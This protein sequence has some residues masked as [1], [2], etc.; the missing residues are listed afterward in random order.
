ME[1]FRANIVELTPS[2]AQLLDPSSVPSLE[3]LV[4][5]GEAL[6]DNDVKLWW[7]KVRCS[8]T[9]EPSEC[10]P[11]TTFNIDSPRIQDATQIGK[12]V[13]AVTWVVDPNNHNVL[14]APGFVGELL[15]QGPVVGQ[16]YMNDE[17]KTAQAFIEDPAW[18]L[19]GPTNRRGRTGACTRL[20][21]L[22]TT[23]KGVA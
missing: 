22:S 13:G 19:Q 9:Y 7:G 14:Q 17:V 20:E 10:T 23:T 1:S 2:V 11:T 5:G 18:L 4:F 12:G 8:N 3:Q 16:G 21:V 15:L 6:R